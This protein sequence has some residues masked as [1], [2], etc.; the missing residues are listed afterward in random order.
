LLSVALVL[1]IQSALSAQ[2]DTLAIT[3]STVINVVDGSVDI[4]NVRRI[5]AVIYRGRLLSEADIDRIIAARR[6]TH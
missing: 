1:S 5:N 3:N 2:S 4:R 6:R